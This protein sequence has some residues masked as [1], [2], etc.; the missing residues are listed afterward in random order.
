MRISRQVVTFLIISYAFL[1]SG[2]EAF[3]STWLEAV[4]TIMAQQDSLFYSWKSLC[5]LLKKMAGI[6]HMK[7]VCQIWYSGAKASRKNQMKLQCNQILPPLEIVQVFLW[8][9]VIAV[10]GLY[11]MGKIKTQDTCAPSGLG[12]F[13]CAGTYRVSDSICLGLCLRAHWQYTSHLLTL[14]AI[15]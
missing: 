1:W 4:G 11:S 13:V 5:I 9:G 14:L 2:I 6:S 7:S 10:L 12:L 3:K 8:I 15:P